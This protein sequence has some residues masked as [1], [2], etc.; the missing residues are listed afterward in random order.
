MFGIYISIRIVVK[1]SWE[2][3][4]LLIEYECIVKG[5]MGW[6]D[7]MKMFDELYCIMYI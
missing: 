4:K 6:E 7:G 5:W 1:Y 2:L 3:R